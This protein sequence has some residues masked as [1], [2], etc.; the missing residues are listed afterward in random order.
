M[1]T[2]IKSFL[3]L[4][5]VVLVVLGMVCCGGTGQRIALDP[6]SQDFYEYASLIMTRVEKNIFNHL[7][8]KE[9]R[10]E[11]IQDFWAK[12]D[13]T[14]DT[15]ENEYQAEFYR[16]IEYANQRFKEGP[17]GWK[18]DRGRIYIYLGP[19]DKF[20]E[21]FVHNEVDFK[22]ERVRGSVLVWYYYRYG[23]AIK[24]V[25]ARGNGQFTFDPMSGLAGSLPDALEMAKLGVS[26]E[27]GRMPERYVD[28]KAEYDAQKKEIVITIPV[29]N[30]NFLAEEGILKADLDFDFHIYQKDGVWKERFR[31]SR[32]FAKPEDEVLK[33]EEMAFSFLHEIKPGRYYLDIIIFGKGSLGKTRKIFEIKV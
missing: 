17:P 10:K 22:G 8:D 18:T 6:E 19:P 13:P 1:Q 30:V 15:E 31:E 2:K 5:A 32:S 7:P 21:F 27:D 20:E 28:F 4:S 11:F 12:R 23:L 29:K 33:M 3:L 26:Y 25:D 14:P 9:S 24:F 16:R